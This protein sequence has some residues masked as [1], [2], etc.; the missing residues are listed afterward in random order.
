MDIVGCFRVFAVLQ[1]RYTEG[2]PAVLT[3]PD[4][5]SGFALG[6][7]GRVV[8]TTPPSAPVVAIQ[9]GGDGISKAESEAGVAVTITGEAD[10][11][12]RRGVQHCWAGGAGAAH[13]QRLRCRVYGVR[14]QLQC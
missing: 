4:P 7:E 1:Q 6:A 8:D 5:A 3:L 9:D 10:A 11:D 12:Y 14:R 13:H 2:N